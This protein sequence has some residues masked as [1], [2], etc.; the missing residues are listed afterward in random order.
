M[1]PLKIQT[2]ASRAHSGPDRRAA[3]WLPK[4]S[5]IVGTLCITAAAHAAEP[6][7]NPSELD[8]ETVGKRGAN[9]FV[10]PV[11]QVLTPAGIQVELPEMRPQGIAL[12]PDGQILV[13]SGKTAEL[14]VVDPVTGA[15]RQRVA[16]PSA[17]ATEPEPDAVSTHI[18]DPDKE[19]QLSFTGLV[20]SPDGKRIYLSN[21][22]GSIKVFQVN[23]K[24]EVRASHSIPLPKADA[25]RRSNEIPAGLA[26]TS[27]GQRL[28][29]ALNL[30]NRMAELDTATGVVKRMWEV[31]VAP[32]DVAL[33][34]G[35]AYVSNWGGRRP[36]KDSLTG[37][38]GRGM[39]V[40]VDPVRHIA[41]EGSV[42]IIG[43]GDNGSSQEI[44]V[45]LHASA[46]AVSP[47]QRHV[48][49]AN[50]GSD[51]LSV[52]D[53][54]TDRIVE[55]IWT[56]AS[57]ADLFGASPNALAFDSRTGQLW[58]CNGTQNAVAIVRF[59]PGRSE[60]LGMVP[61]AWFPGAI[62]LDSHRK[63]FYVANTKG[64]GSTKHYAAGEKVK[65]NSHQYFGSLSLIPQPNEKQLREHTRQVY[66]NYRRSVLT[67]ALKPARPGMR[68][69]PV[70]ERSG[71]PSVFKHVVY[72]IKENRTYDQV[73]GDL[74][75]GN[76][77]S[78]LCIFGEKFTP[79]Q[80]KMVREFTLL[81]NT[82][83]SG[84]LSADG[85]QW[86]DTGFA[87]DYMEKSFAGFPRS[88]PDGM[89]DDDI[90]ALA[91][92]P[93]G[94]LWDKALAHGKSV[95]IYGE[96]AITEAHWR[97]R[98]Q[99]GAPKFM[100]FYNDF[101]TQGD[102]IQ[103]FSRPAIGSIKPYLATNTVGWH[104]DIPDVFRAKKFI[105]EL[106]GYEQSG[107]LPNLVVICL[108]NDHTS[109]T[110]SQA[111]TPG[112]Q[113][114]DND[115]A[116]GQ[117]LE[118][119]SHSR[120][121]KETC[122]FAIEDDPQAGWDHV[123][124]YRTTA[125][126]ASPYTKRGAVVSTQYNQTSLLRTMGLMLGLPP[127]NQMDGSATPMTDCFTDVPDLRPFDA[128]P[129]NIPLDELNPE[130]KKVSNTL[131]RHHILV[132][133]RLP[134]KEPDRCPED[135]L[136]RILW[137]AMKGPEAPYPNWAVAKVKDHDDD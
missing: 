25:P 35:K 127:M 88:Y 69:K 23:E 19:G 106:K 48:V 109:G 55:T 80:H 40:R 50:A 5:V 121:W 103:I 125:Y 73:F 108:P 38:A 83:C 71:E 74:P 34:N 115:L 51:N 44:L 17:K 61:T 130:P 77:D 104:M 111:P 8:K 1:N 134:L 63:A 82:Y 14:V 52:I 79:N 7:L 26:I 45:G 46:L 59:R 110:K 30:S 21:V 98:S 6:A 70:P 49:V 114:A 137:H 84:I 99:K 117:I 41:N 9:R 75:Q 58:V 66:A 128:V 16:L 112:A 90:D 57:P 118:A 113:V 43:L 13:T 92:A 96:F 11:N 86:A 31:G 135:A 10:T 81:D 87:T 24:H 53:T 15:I 132:S 97:D 116:F 12:S 133:N 20:F 47:N 37:P 67:E 18:L 27:D 120:F 60:V 85:H 100:D 102:K 56:K 64:I 28:Y 101:R 65:F 123:S 89:E 93:S 95:R 91:Y 126:V 78:S 76:G 62:A 129:N 33:A 124:G 136:N 131:L 119:I 3:G 36:D 4:L 32:Y 54:R 29:V 39:K 68:P 105:E 22:N 94:F 107:G 2:H 42:T 72:I 122:V